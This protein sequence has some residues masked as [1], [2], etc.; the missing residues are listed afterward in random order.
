MLVKKT[1]VSCY[2]FH[3]IIQSSVGFHLLHLRS[4]QSAQSSNLKCLSTEA[5]DS[6]ISIN[7]RVTMCEHTNQSITTFQFFLCIRSATVGM[8]LHSTTKADVLPL[9]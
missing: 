5:N 4:A 8:E 6:V 7:S 2:H 9:F 3:K 1:T